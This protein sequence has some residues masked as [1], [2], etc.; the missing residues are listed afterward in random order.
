MLTPE[1]KKLFLD[2]CF[3]GFN[4][5]TICTTKSSSLLV[6]EYT[7]YLT[8]KLC[9]NPLSL[10]HERQLQKNSTLMILANRYSKIRGVIPRLSLG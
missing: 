9:F 4:K 2:S 1:E 7:T 3:E 6:G 10:F 8:I 5:S